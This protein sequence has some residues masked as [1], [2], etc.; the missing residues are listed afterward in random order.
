MSLE[1]AQGLLR[2][3]Y[4]VAPIFFAALLLDRGYRLKQKKAFREL[5]GT[6]IAAAMI[7]T[8]LSVVFALA[9]G[10]RVRLDQAFL[11]SLYFFG[12]MVVLKA[13]DHLLRRAAASL[14]RLQCSIDSPIKTEVDTDRSNRLAAIIDQPIIP[15]WRRYAAGTFRILL[16][17]AIGLPYIMAAAMAY[18]PKVGLASDPLQQMGWR[19]DSFHFPA[20]DGTKISAW[21]IPAPPM[22]AG[23]SPEASRDWARRTVLVCH[24][25]GA[26]KLNQLHMGRAFH[27]RGWNLLAIDFRAH[28]GSAGQF[29][30]FGDHE[31]RDVFGAVRWLK[32]H[33]PGNARQIVGVGASLGAAALIAAA[34]E[35]DS[36]DGRAISGLLIY[37]TYADLGELA[38][39]ITRDRLP[40]GFGLLAR[41]VA[42]PLASLHAGSNLTAFCPRES[43]SRLGDRPILII[44][45]TR[46][47]IIPVPHAQSLFRA[48]TGPKRLILLDS[49][50]NGIIENEA[51]AQEGAAFFDILK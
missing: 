48:A 33:H 8:A 30:S 3:I 39:T 9:V 40:W 20:T 25:L 4:A 11:A 27:A 2:A 16:L 31:R 15:A 45:G 35:T 29:S 12:V 46:D 21:Y 50:H 42:I 41:F 43:L 10:A 19:F 26:N 38:N 47:E 22:P 18:R 37:A 32:S 51:A 23:L 44:H 14:F 13:L 1:L 5:L 17:A 6:A 34:G 49:D 24:G 7:G 36:P 28:G